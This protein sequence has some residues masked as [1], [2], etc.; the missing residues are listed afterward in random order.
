[1]V[2]LLA[3][4]TDRTA[5]VPLLYCAVYY[6]EIETPA[7][8]IQAIYTVLAKRRGHVTADVP[9]PGED[10]K[11]D[12]DMRGGVLVLGPGT[13]GVIKARKLTTLRS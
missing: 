3:A 1:M 7:D 6:V 9:K 13:S 11:S 4:S 12:G 5:V 2:Y 10:L 8:C